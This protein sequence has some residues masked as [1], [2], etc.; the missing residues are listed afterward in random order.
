MLDAWRIAIPPVGDAGDIASRIHVWRSFTG[1]VA[2][3]AV[4]KR[5]AAPFEPLG[6]WF[7]SDADYHYFGFDQ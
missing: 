4:V 5:E 1:A 7:D 6:V 2:D 3:D